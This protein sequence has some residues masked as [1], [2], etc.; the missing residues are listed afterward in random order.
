MIPQRY[1]IASL[2]IAAMLLLVALVQGF[3]PASGGGVA[4][5]DAGA[6]ALSFETFPVTAELRLEDGWSPRFQGTRDPDQLDPWPFEGGFGAPWEPASPYLGDQGIA[7][8]GPQGRGEVALWRGL[9]WRHYHFDAPLVSARLDPARGNR[10]LVTLGLG[11]DRFETQLLEIP[12]GRVLWSLRAGPWSRFAWDGRA[13]LVGAFEPKPEGHGGEGKGDT[14]LLSAMP[15]EGEPGEPTLAAWDEASLPPAPRGVPTRSELL[16][17]DGRDLP[18]AKLA[19]PWRAGDRFWMPRRDRLWV[20]SANGWSL[21]RLEDG[22]WH[23]DA[24]GPGLLVAQPPLGVALTAPGPAEGAARSTAPLDRADWKAV[25]TGAGPWPAYDPAW[26]WTEGAALTAWDARWGDFGERLAP[27]RQ[28][29]AV[30]AAFRPDWISAKA[31]R[32][33]VAG[34]LPQGPEVALREVQSSA[35]VWAGDRVLLVHLPE[36]DRLRRVRKI[37]GS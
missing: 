19:L 35:W 3:R 4:R 16:S 5:P 21:W 17:D 6:V 13:V 24:A 34:W 33:S 36:L 27:E 10:L 1:L 12:E 31:L 29:I 23:R 20:G 9:E 8:N 26:A 32:R 11:N 2:F 7:L 22:R 15:V 14:L 28:R 37:V 18:G 25:P 30:R